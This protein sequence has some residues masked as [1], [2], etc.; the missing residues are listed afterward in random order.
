MSICA[1]PERLFSKGGECSQMSTE[2]TI[3][4]G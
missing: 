4:G 3:F 1:L 2:K